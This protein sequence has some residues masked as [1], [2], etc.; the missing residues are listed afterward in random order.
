MF[1]CLN[2]FARSNAYCQGVKLVQAEAVP[3]LF[4]SV[5]AVNGDKTETYCPFEIPNPSTQYFRAAGD[6]HLWQLPVIMLRFQRF[7]RLGSAL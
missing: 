1:G 6:M 5:G 4:R 2:V 7:Q 3:F